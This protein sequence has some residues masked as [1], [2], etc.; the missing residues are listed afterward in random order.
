PCTGR[1]STRNLPAAGSREQG[2]GKPKTM[3][4]KSKRTAKDGMVVVDCDVHINDLPQF[5]AP[6]CVMPWRKS[7]EML[8]KTPQ[9]YLDIPGYSPGFKQYPPIPG[10]QPTRSVNTAADLRREL[11]AIDIDYGIL[12]PDH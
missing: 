4:A 6:H 11:D 8:G 9:R 2:P 12:I 5:L 1:P 10:G 7:L 3:V